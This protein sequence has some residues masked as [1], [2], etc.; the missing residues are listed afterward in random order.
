MGLPQTPLLIAMRIPLCFLSCTALPHRMSS[1]LNPLHSGV[2]TWHLVCVFGFASFL[3]YST[4]DRM[5]SA[6]PALGISLSPVPHT[7]LCTQRA[8]SISITAENISEMQ[9]SFEGKKNV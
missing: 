5:N 6:Y 8:F 2:S 9:T 4:A 7:R 3:L 1:A